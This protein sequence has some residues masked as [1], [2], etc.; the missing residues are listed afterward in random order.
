[1]DV[2]WTNPGHVPQGELVSPVLDIQYGDEGNDFELTHSTGD[3]RLTDGCLI[4]VEGTE[5]G[6]R[7][8]GIRVE[9]S[10]GHAEYTAT[11][12]TWHGML[13]GKII[14]P[15]AGMNRLVLSGDANNV[16]RTIISRT[17]LTDTFAVPSTSSGFTV[18]SYAFH[19]YCTAWDGLRM[20]L[21]SVGARL[22]MRFLD[23]VCRLEAV[24]SATYGGADSDQRVDFTAKRAY[25]QVNHLIGLGK[26]ELANRA[27]SHWYADEQ[28]NISQTQSLTGGREICQTYELTTS[29]GSELSDKTRDKLKELWAQGT[30]ELALPDDLNLH[31][32]DHVKAYD[33]TTGISVDS[34][35]VRISMK[36][37]NGIPQVSY[38]TGS[39]DW[40]QEEA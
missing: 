3:V 25:T 39:Y 1:M 26:G 32:D 33:A 17:G 12:R 8:D 22:S 6:G 34:P 35:I 28:G 16:I 4:G 38:E 10:D 13:A 19:R 9:M 5:Y 23:G 37:K 40:P 14:Q 11:G 30:V 24:E 20:M 21:T 18:S 29:E 7:V 2:I 27:V 15:D 36:L 31:V